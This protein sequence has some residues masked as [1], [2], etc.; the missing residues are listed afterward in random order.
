MLLYASFDFLNAHI[1]IYIFTLKYHWFSLKPNELCITRLKSPKKVYGLY[2]ML[3][4][5]W[6][7]MVESACSRV[8]CGAVAA[9][10]TPEEPLPA[11][12]G[13]SRKERLGL[14]RA[15]ISPSSADLPIRAGL[16]P[17]YTRALGRCWAGFWATLDLIDCK[18]TT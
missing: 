6:A 7:K 9:F 1:Y 2:Q 15:I 5:H 18:P 11:D 10:E 13:G 4:G 16:A 17:T 3:E 8:S 12:L 14:L